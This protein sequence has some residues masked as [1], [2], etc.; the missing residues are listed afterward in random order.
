[1][2]QTGEQSKKALCLAEPEDAPP[3]TCVPPPGLTVGGAPPAPATP[4]APDTTATTT[5]LTVKFTHYCNCKTCCGKDSDDPAYG[6][7]ADGSTA[8]TGTL[9]APKKYPFGTTITWTDPQGNDH[10]G[11]VHDRGGAIKGNRIDIWVSSHAEALRLGT[12][13]V[14]ATITIP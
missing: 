4:A 8:G 13:T 6:I 14:D 11:T 9:A 1:M 3:P 5:T 2:P 12:Y 10:T 7:T